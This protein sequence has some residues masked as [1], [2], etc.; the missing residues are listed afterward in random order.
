MKRKVFGTKNKEIIICFDKQV[1]FK[2]LAGQTKQAQE[3][4]KQSKA[5]VSLEW[6]G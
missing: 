1:R 4:T 3:I 2:T 6:T 5:E